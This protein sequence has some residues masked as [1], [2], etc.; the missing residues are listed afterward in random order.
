MRDEHGKFTSHETE[1]KRIE[2]IRRALGGHRT[3]E[4][5]EA[6]IITLEGAE[7]SEMLRDWLTLVLEEKQIRA[8]LPE[9]GVQI[10]HTISVKKTNINE[11]TAP[12]WREFFQSLNGC[13]FESVES[14]KENLREMLNVIIAAEAFK[15]DLV[16]EEPI[17]FISGTDI[18]QELT[19]KLVIILTRPNEFGSF[20]VFFA[21]PSSIK[22]PEWYQQFKEWALVAEFD[23]DTTVKKFLKNFALVARKYS[24]G[25]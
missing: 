9:G 3:N 23:D 12:S 21:E 19:G 14:L 22:M 18:H 4:E 10:Q 25:A 20:K 13:Q 17:G 8:P 15:S 11:S 1:Q 16:P 2:F 24:R 7:V 5:I 6:A